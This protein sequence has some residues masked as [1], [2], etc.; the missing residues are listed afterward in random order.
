MGDHGLRFGKIRATP[1][2]QIE[3]NNPF[4]MIAVPKYLR[5]NEQLILNLKQNSRRHTSHFDF[6]ATLYDIVRYARNDNFR[7]WDEYD[8]RT[9]EEMEIPMEYCICQQIWHKFDIHNDD[10]TKAA[11]LIITDINDFLKRKTLNGICEMLRF[12]EVIISAE[13]L[14]EESTLKIVVRASPS[15]GKYEAQIT[16]LD[17]YGNQ[18]YCAPAEDV[19][20]LCYCR[21]QLTT[22][23]T[24]H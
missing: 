7:K 20:H 2:G 22:V 4:F 3:D 14:E 19:R 15:D 10:A 9:C 8:F 1:P 13:Y 18:G 6:Y 12:I 21:K 16:R 17:Q 24:M 5:S 11:H 23:S